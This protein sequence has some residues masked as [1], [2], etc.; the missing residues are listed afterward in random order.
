MLGVLLPM[1]ASA[2]GDNTLSLQDAVTRSLQSNPSLSGYSYRFKAID[3]YTQQAATATPPVIGLEVEDALGT[4][5]YSEFDSA[6]TTLSISWIL[7]QALI[8]QRVAT[9]ESTRS[10]VEINQQVQRYDVAA[11][12]ARAYLAVLGLQERL[13][14]AE[15]AHKLA[16]DALAEVAR[17]VDLGKTPIVDQLKAEVNRERRAQDVI[18][19]EHEL[20]SAKRMLAAQ[21]GAASAEFSAVSG[22][23]KASASLPPFAE[24]EQAIAGNP[25]LQY[26]LTQERVL[27]S[28]IALARAEYKNRL[29]FSAG[30]RRFEATDDYGVVAGVS[31]PL[32]GSNRN[33]GKISALRAEQDVYR[34]DAQAAEI[35]LKARLFVLHQE[36]Q[37]SLGNREA[38]EQRIIPRLERALTETQ[39]AYGIG[40]YTYLEWASLQQEL[41]DARQALI[42][43]GLSSQLNATEIERLTGQMVF[44][45]SEENK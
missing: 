22:S 14:L 37:R 24:L 40:K 9:A 44:P 28:E 20:E 21:W 10:L 32:G 38:L 2:T 5:D 11:E 33:A 31:L 16:S 12:T 29:A 7:E 18:N 39:K 34:S 8:D 4:G 36:I 41:L 19:I 25:S 35:A 42:D 13:L 43:A 17:R 6:Q 27:E 30:L 26:F 23:L 45:S 15:S 1:V 3:G